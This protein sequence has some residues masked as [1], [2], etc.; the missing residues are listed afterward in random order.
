MSKPGL[1][2]PLCFLILSGCALSESPEIIPDK[3]EIVNPVTESQTIATAPTAEPI[4]VVPPPAVIRSF[5]ADEIRRLQAGLR[6]VGLD[7]GP[8]DGI[9]GGKTRIAIE[10]LQS[11][12][13][14]IAP[15][16][17]NFA[18]MLLP[19]TPKSTSR[20]EIMALQTELRQAGF[21]PGQVDGVLGARTRAVA[22]Q[23]QRHCP[24]AH[25]YA[26]SLGSQNEIAKPLAAGEPGARVIKTSAALNSAH[27]EP[28]KSTAV[29]AAVA[30]QEEIRLLQLRLRDTG[31][32]P[33]AFDGVMGPRTM[34]ALEEFEAAQRAGKI[35]PA[36]ASGISVQY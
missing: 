7:P 17:E 19:N 26:A 6:E 5:S 12:C 29:P 32:D 33:G 3:S 16:I 21:N 20:Q 27:H 13:A 1:I 11:G 18:P 2:F 10:R 8:V 9:A 31:F 23:L 15:K 30:S 22:A 28:G 4:E 34:K 24:M 36:S 35:K 25:E 14:Q